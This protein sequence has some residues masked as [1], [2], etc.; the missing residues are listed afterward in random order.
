M[1][2]WNNFAEG[3]GQGQRM[4][5]Q[6]SR[7]RAGNLLASGDTQGGVN[8]LY[9][10]G[11]FDEAG[12]MQ[13]QQYRND[14]LQY[15]RD[16][17][18]ANAEEKQ[19]ERAVA[20][21]K[22]RGTFFLQAADAISKI[23]DDGSQAQRRQALQTLVPTFQAMG[24]APEHIQALIGVDLSDQ[25]LAMLKG[26]LSKEL[27]Q[28]TLG[29]GSTRYDSTGRVI[30]SQPFAPQYRSVG[31]GENL[32][33]VNP[34]SGQSAPQGDWLSGIVQAA[35]D[36]QVTSGYRTAEH[37]AAV[38][39]VPN[40]RHLSGQAVD[41][42]PKPGESMAQ[43][44]ER[45][46]G[47]PGVKAINEGDHV[48]VQATGSQGGARVIAQGA[49]KEA[50]VP[51][52]YRQGAGGRLEFIPG[53]P[54]DPATKTTAGL[55]PVP[56]A[57]QKGY[58]ENN[59]TIKQIDE[60]IAAIRANPQALG[61]KNY[62]GDAIMQRVDQDGVSVRAAVSNIGSK[63]IHDRSGAAVTAAE[64][65]RLKPFVPQATDTPEAA[66][67]KLQGLRQ[68][69]VNETSGIEVAYGEDSGYRPLGGTPAPQAQAPATQPARAPAKASVAAIPAAAIGYLKKNPNLRNAFDAKYG[70]G[71][72]ARALGR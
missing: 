71:A 52:G 46:R 51:S 72:A 6:F 69:V 11:L 54:A 67:K 70:A 45:V 59:A 58:T 5:D 1:P 53:G 32:V 20:E 33:E 36:A 49:P 24:I 7:Q 23:P 60:A 34:Q 66:I 4:F 63:L 50:A 27:E 26:N 42:V 61:L 9:K 8:A 56:V 10:G 39:G 64:T 31:P 37:N 25:S 62:A 12:Q 18:K 2:G 35:P 14:Y 15:Q 57:I 48:H 40:S 65:P 22:E 38:G 68:Q 17:M 16:A 30:A 28:F 44:Y 55:K 13:D 19:Q 41:L 47:V 43:L 3:W 21:R 29:P